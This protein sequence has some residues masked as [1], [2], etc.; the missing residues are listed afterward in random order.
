MVGGRMIASYVGDDSRIYSVRRVA[1][2]A[3][4]SVR[5]TDNGRLVEEFSFAARLDD[6]EQIAAWRILEG[7]RR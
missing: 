7:L 2:A 1:G 3:W 6:R 4:A 5:V